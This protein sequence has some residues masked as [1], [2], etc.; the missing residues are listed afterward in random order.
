[1]SENEYAEKAEAEVAE[2]NATHYVQ[3][4]KDK[5][6][7]VCVAK[8]EYEK[9]VKQYEAMKEAGLEAWIAKHPF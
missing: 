4:L 7:K 5:W 9:A 1:M 3:A 8:L 6:R 2:E